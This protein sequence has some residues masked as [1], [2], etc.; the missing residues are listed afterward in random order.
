MPYGLL[1]RSRL[2]PL[3]PSL[4]KV[5]RHLYNQQ[6]NLVRLC[7]G[8]GIA[9]FGYSPL[10]A[11]GYVAI[12]LASGQGACDKALDEPLVKAIATRLG[13]TPA[14]VQRT[15]MIKLVWD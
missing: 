12:G 3:I 14:Q 2:F 7:N 4:L 10:G 5:E 11:L 15:P 8:L 6:M 1:S 13:K 9:V